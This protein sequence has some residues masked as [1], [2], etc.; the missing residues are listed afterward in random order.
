MTKLVRLF[1]NAKN[2]N[3]KKLKPNINVKR[4]V[5]DEYKLAKREFLVFSVIV[6]FYAQMR[7]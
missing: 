3:I 7:D 2:S 6:I 5:F 4:I 1:G